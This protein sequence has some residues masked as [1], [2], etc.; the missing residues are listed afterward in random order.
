[1]SR[2]PTPLA[3]T[4]AESK[5]AEG[6]RFRRGTRRQGCQ[7]DRAQ[8]AHPLEESLVQ[9]DLL[10]VAVADL[11]LLTE[12]KPSFQFEMVVEEAV[13]GARVIHLLPK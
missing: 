10:D 12:K 8:A 4:V 7:I 5:G 3:E 13:F 1:M 9:G 11:F 2:M 6:V